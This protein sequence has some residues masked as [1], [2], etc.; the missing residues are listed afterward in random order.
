MDRLKTFDGDVAVQLAPTLGLDLPS[1]IVI[2]RGQTGVDFAVKADPQRAP[3]RQGI[4]LNATAVVNG[5]EEEQ[6]GRFDVDIV[7]MPVQKK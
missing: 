6:R 2:P 3:G 7:K 1:M 4:N 5:F